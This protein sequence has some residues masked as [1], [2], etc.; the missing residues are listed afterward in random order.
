MCV[1]LHVNFTAIIVVRLIAAA[2][3]KLNE[4]ANVLFGTTLRFIDV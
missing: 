4:T 2:R 3:K 1:L